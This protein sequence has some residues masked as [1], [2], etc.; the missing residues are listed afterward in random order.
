MSTPDQGHVIEV[1]AAHED[2]DPK[3]LST[4]WILL[5]VLGLAIV[6]VVAGRMLYHQGFDS[7]TLPAELV[8]LWTTAD[9]NYSDRYLELQPDTITFGTGGTSSIK[10]SIIGVVRPEAGEGEAYEIHFR[11][12]NGTKFSREIVLSGSGEK[13]FF[14]SQPDVVWTPFKR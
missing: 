3:G 6:A 10:Y 1:V 5:I 11:G 12:V 14:R 9:P 4:G 13:L 7:K 2:V 8:G